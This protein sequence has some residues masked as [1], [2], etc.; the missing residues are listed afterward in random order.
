MENGKDN[1]S[2]PPR[3]KGIPH[4]VRGEIGVKAWT[5]NRE[6]FGKQLTLEEST[7][8]AAYAINV[9]RWHDAETWIA[10]HGTTVVIRDKD[11]RAKQVIKA[12]QTDIANQAAKAC[13]DYAAKLRELE[14]LYRERGREVR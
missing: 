8:L 3:P 5:Q 6:R 9:Q 10:Q 12:P 2:E 11:G 1:P 4:T 13:S 7:A 14:R